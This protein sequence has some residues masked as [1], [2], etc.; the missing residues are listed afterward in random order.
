[1]ERCFMDCSRYSNFNSIV[2]SN[3]ID[4]DYIVIW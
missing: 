2:V 4:V 3:I 1:M